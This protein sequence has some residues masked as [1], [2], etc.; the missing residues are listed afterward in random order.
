MISDD[1]WAAFSGR[2][3]DQNKFAI[4]LGLD[5]IRRA[6]ALHGH[7]ERHAPAIVVGGT[8]G[9]GSTAAYLSAILTAHGLKTGLF[10]SPHLLELRERFR[11]DGAPASRESV[12]AHGEAVLA[13]H[14]DPASDPCL[15]FFELTTLTAALLF[16]DAN[17]DVVVWEVGLG[18]RLD[19]VNAIEP[20]LT[21]VTNIGMDHEKWLG[22]S[23]EAIAREKAG[24][25]RDGVRM[26]VGP[27]THPE[28]EQMLAALP[29]ARLVEVSNPNERSRSA[30]ENQAT[31]LY[32]SR[33]Y[34]GPRWIPPVAFDALD[35]VVWPGRM[36]ERTAR[37][38]RFLLDAAH[39]PAGARRLEARIRADGP[40]TR[41][42]IGAMADKDLRGMFGFLGEMGIP[43]DIVEVESERAAS[44]EDIREAVTPA[45]V[46][47]HGRSAQIFDACPTEGWTLVFG[48]I[49]L[50][51]EWFRWAGT[52]VDELVT[53]R[54]V[55]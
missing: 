1:A 3:F 8:N 43:I 2:L 31:A 23:I 41:C 9:K 12:L 14:G 51:G 15:T 26:V 29:G 50:L 45:E 54:P 42:V 11:V 39:N 46:R 49:Y 33:E 4:K 36:D 30:S 37:G 34:L 18:G 6:F 38:R 17:V 22:D 24:L 19:A 32:A 16:R 55:G 21:I 13:A 7:P 53:T 20:A 5:N 52:G 40:P 35:S 10:T 27:Q 44:F 28:A 25:W 47:S 48:S